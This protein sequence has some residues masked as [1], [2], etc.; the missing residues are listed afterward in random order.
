MKKLLLLTFCILG[1]EVDNDTRKAIYEEELKKTQSMKDCSVEVIG[2]ML[3]LYIVRCPL[4]QTSVMYMN[5]KRSVNSSLV[6]ADAVPKE[7]PELTALK[8]KAEKLGFEVKK[9]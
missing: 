3:R 7:D 4:S 5:G 9:K 6:V 2:K 8:E 1:C